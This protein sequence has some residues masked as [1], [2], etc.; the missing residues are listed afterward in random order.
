MPGTAF[1]RGNRVVL[2]TIEDEDVEVLQ[3]ARNEPAFRDGLMGK[4]PANRTRIESE[5]EE[6]AEEDD[7][8]S[9]AL[10]I[11]VDEEAVGFV[12]LFDI[13]SGESGTLGYWL[14]PEYQGN[15]YVTEGAGLLIDHG[16]QNLA[17]HRVF[18]WTIDDNEASQAV[19]RR[20]GFSHEGT[21]REHIFRRGDYHDTEH[22]GLLV[23]E[24]D[25]YDGL[26]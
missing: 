26:E 2:R 15:G 6:R 14:L 22:Y 20:L 9:V 21:H 4:Y 11:C 24:W 3:R 17:L 23:S 18:A 5:I 10:L 7:D 12:C 25:G 13:H 19:L 8:D 1:L 16:F